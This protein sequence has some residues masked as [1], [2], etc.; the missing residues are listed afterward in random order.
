MPSSCHHFREFS[1]L[2]DGWLMFV[3]QFCP[4]NSNH[5]HHINIAKQYSS[6]INI[7][8]CGFNPFQK[9]CWSICGH[10]PKLYWQKQA[11]PP[12][13]KWSKY[14]CRAQ[15][16]CSVPSKKWLRRPTW[17]L[18]LHL[19]VRGFHNPSETSYNDNLKWCWDVSNIYESQHAIQSCSRISGPFT[20]FRDL[21]PPVH[22]C[23]KVTEVHVKPR[24]HTGNHRGIKN[25]SSGTT[26]HLRIRRRR[27]Q[28]VTCF[29]WRN[30]PSDVPSKKFHE[31]KGTSNRIWGDVSWGPSSGRHFLELHHKSLKNK[32]PKTNWPQ[33]LPMPQND[34]DFHWKPL[35][36]CVIVSRISW[37]KMP[38]SKH[39][40]EKNLLH[41]DQRAT[42]ITRKNTYMH[43]NCECSFFIGAYMCYD[44]QHPAQRIL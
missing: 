37:K 4:D 8:L 35:P 14:V 7:T 1:F 25:Y 11:K 30:V 27:H 40:R 44:W 21:V 33:K 10:L 38:I 42:D 3:C 9:K 28:N 29:M 5:K 17:K 16:I 36:E 6:D 31:M 23:K 15:I 34:I 43:K 22:P 19:L 18:S 20:S 24:S 26:S 32:L 39:S 13:R 12:A 2:L 41:W